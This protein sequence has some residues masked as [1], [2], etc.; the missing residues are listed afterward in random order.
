MNDFLGVMVIFIIIIYTV[1]I[2]LGIIIAVDRR[3]Y[4][5]SLCIGVETLLKKCEDEDVVEILSQMQ[6]FYGN[7]I[8]F[9]PGAKRYYPSFSYWINYVMLQINLN[10]KITKRIN[11]YE[12]ILNKVIEQYESDNP[13]NKCTDYQQNL[14]RDMKE[15]IN[16]DNKIVLS[17]IIYRTEEEF[18]RLSTEIKKNDK[19]NRLSIGIGVLGIVVSVVVAIINF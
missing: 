5:K 16:D 9:N 12:D 14:L 1:L 4:T 19:L 6:R 15:V 3:D 11:Q 18:I 13:F 7:Y 10:R 2:L 8:Q 17:N